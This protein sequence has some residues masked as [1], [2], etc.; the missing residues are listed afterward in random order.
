MKEIKAIVKRNMLD[1]VIDS[2]QELPHLPGITMS[3]VYGFNRNDPGG[4]T[5]DLTG[6]AKMA[7][8]E[9]VVPDAL[10]EKVIETIAR[11]ARTG[12]AG[13]G[14]IFLYDVA[15]VVKIRTGERGAGAV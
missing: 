2:L 4:E 3:M 14:K 6:E 11:A 10:V 1:K 7:K 9:V 12:L 15:D 5:P 8:L 13:D